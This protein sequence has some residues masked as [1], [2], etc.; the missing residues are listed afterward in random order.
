MTGSVATCGP[1]ILTFNCLGRRAAALH[2]RYAGRNFLITCD[3]VIGP[4]TI[5]VRP[6]GPLIGLISFYSGVTAS[7]ADKAQLVLDLGALA[8][9]AYAGTEPTTA[10][11]R[12]GQP[13]VLVV[14]DSRLAREAG[15]K[16][17]IAALSL[18]ECRAGG[19]VCC[20][21]HRPVSFSNRNYPH[22]FT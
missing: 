16:P 12:R 5:V 19:S 8:D 18:D 14:D 22:R 6:P 20:R 10:P 2:V 1:E 3:K 9:V 17:R 7:G 15:G 13:R 4:R 21:G 11:P